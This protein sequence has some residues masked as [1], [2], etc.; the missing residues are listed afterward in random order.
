MMKKR[1]I[2]TKVCAL[3]SVF[4][5]GA[6][7]GCAMVEG[8]VGGSS[9]EESSAQVESPVTSTPEASEEPESSLPEVSEEPESSLPEVSE[10]PETPEAPEEKPEQTA[11]SVLTKGEVFPYIDNVKNYLQA[12]EG[13]RV[14]DYHQAVNS[15]WAPVEIKW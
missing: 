13:A 14:G 5:M 1:N 9:V 3:C 8:I 15:Q 10:E 6:F 11:L 12:G 7:S 2:L 4:T